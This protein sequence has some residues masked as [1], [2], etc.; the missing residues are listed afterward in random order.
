VV[1]NRFVE[2]ADAASIQDKVQAVADAMHDYRMVDEP[3]D[4]AGFLLAADR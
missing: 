2:E 3:V 1:I 4:V